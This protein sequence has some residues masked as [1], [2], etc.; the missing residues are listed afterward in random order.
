MLWF[1]LFNEGVSTKMLKSVKAMYHSV[2]SVIKFHN[3][4]SLS[5]DV[6]NGVKQG[7]PLSPLLFIFFINDMMNNI[8]PDTDLD[9][10][11]IDKLPLFALMYADDAVIF[12]KSKTG[13]Q[14][15][16]DKLNVYCKRWNL[17]VNVDKTKV[18]IFEKGR[19][20]FV[21]IGLYFDGTKLELVASFKYL[22]LTFFKNGKWYRSQKIFS[23]YGTFALHRLQCIFHIFDR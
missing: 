9:V 15:M 19:T 11:F 22:G 5:F 20:T 13:L 10:F 14:N 16:L 18:M 21:D 12:S 3:N 4:F 1:K 2:K 6:L 7:D 17:K 23:Q 8:K